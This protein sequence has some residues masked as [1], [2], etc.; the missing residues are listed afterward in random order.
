MNATSPVH[1]G[2]HIHGELPIPRRQI[3]PLSLRPG[4]G[5]LCRRI[6]ADTS[7]SRFT[8][9]HLCPRSNPSTPVRPSNTQ[10]PTA[11]LSHVCLRIFAHH[12]AASFKPHSYVA[13]SSFSIVFPLHVM[14]LRLVTGRPV[15]YY[16]NGL[17]L[18]IKRQIAG[19][20]TGPED[21][22]FPWPRFATM[23]GLMTIG[24]TLPGVLWFSAISLAP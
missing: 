21:A 3:G 10:I 19:V 14:Y 4:S 15:K 6:P 8:D 24:I 9:R 13:H 18:A 16:L 2:P 12:R 7:K 1:R 22:K 20:P 23:V 11:I 17:S 5:R